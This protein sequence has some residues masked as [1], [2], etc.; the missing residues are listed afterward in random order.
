MALIVQLS[1]AQ[2]K[3]ISGTVSDENGLPLLGATV[4][5]SG[6]SSGTT[7][8]FDGNYKINATTGDVLSFSYVGYESQNI[9]VGA[10]NTVNVTLQ[11]DNTLDEV[12]VTAYG[13]KRAARETVY[14]TQ[15]ISNEDLVIVQPQSVASTLAGKVAGLQI[16][17]QNNGVNPSS[18]I[19]LRGLRSITQ[20]NAPLIVIDNSISSQGAFDQ[21]N[22]NDVESINTLKG[23]TAAALYGSRASNGA[24]LV[25]TKKGTGVGKFTV[26][27]N[28]SFNIQ[29]V[30]YIPEFQDE[31]GSGWQGVYE[32]IENTNWGPAFDG[33]LRR[34]G[35]VF[36]DGSFQTVPYAPVKDQI[37]DFYNTGTSSNNTVYLSGSDESASFYLSFGKL[38]TTGVMP[39]DT[40]QRNTFRANATKNIGNLTLGIN[41]SYASDKTSVVGNTIGAQDR[42]IYWFILN[43]PINTP[44]TS[45]KDWEN[46]F[47][48]SPDGYPNGYYENPYWAI[49]NN[50]DNDSSRRF[51]A[52]ISVDWEAADWLNLTAR[53]GVNNL[54]RIGK[55]YR[56]AS[57]FQDALLVIDDSRPNPSTSWVEDFESQRS[58]YTADFLASGDFNLNEDFTLK[59]VLGVSNFTRESRGSTIRANNLIIPNM[60]DITNT[61]Q[62]V[63]PNVNESRQRTYGVFTDLT[64]GYKDFLFLN[65]SGRKDWTSTLPLDKNSYFYPGYGLSFLFSDLIDS[66]VLNY[67]RLTI[68][69]S[70][71]Y[72]D[73]EPYEIVEVFTQQIGFPYS[74]TGING[75]ILDATA[76]DENI[77]KEQIKTLEFGLTLGF[78]KDRIKL[79]SSYYKTKTTDL[80]TRATTPPSSASDSYLTNIGLIE[81]SGLEL[82]LDLT[83]IRTE[84]FNWDISTNY[85]SSQQEVVKI[86][87]TLSEIQIGGY[88]TYGI[89]AVEGEQMP[90]IKATSY[91][92]DNQGRVIIDASTGNPIQG[93]LKN[94]GQTTPKYILG[95]TNSFNYKGFS[96]TATMDYRTGHVYVSQLADQ[97]EFT[98]RSQASVSANRQDFV[99]PNSV[100]NAG[101]AD[102]PVYV[103]NTNIQV[104]DGLQNFW[105]DTY[106]DI[107]ENYVF[108][109]TAVKLRELSLGY[110]FPA[111]LLKNTSLSRVN[112]SVYARNVFTW[113]PAEN[114]FSDPEFNGFGD[115]SLTAI[116]DGA[117]GTG[118]ASNSIGIGGYNQAPPTR[119]FGFNL[120]IEF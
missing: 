88:T 75:F 76:V 31:Y 53:F 110:Q 5:I 116:S 104:T 85:T 59:T 10:S 72:N 68:N 38:N 82:T 43:A 95:L 100:Y 25:T 57:T 94:L 109:A 20:S 92:R 113:L 61:T 16:N 63:T 66:S 56:N 21:L 11:L 48:S 106:N 87:E 58:T 71:V 18:Q 17:V 119:T 32:A 39:S 13:I 14:Q 97:M 33:T 51:T 67:G 50:R 24:I 19:L 6:T 117:A 84:N 74:S 27:I 108:D 26:G 107:K 42:P 69:N 91:Q 73:F 22:P 105:T 49:D 64:F 28:S 9:S 40:Y 55:E 47:F 79:N 96:L 98:G 86:S 70:T 23:A 44:L 52:N 114:K 101:T 7:T 12:V 45:Y 80:I 112:L 46:D 93:D 8:D 118:T 4:L 115:S 103:E 37:K 65:V 34:L 99:F 54:N 41:S 78:L 2:Q 62:Q 120:N 89:Y 1:F 29:S 102:N 3:T 35:P 111:K 81:G 90:L 60:Y 77:K 30:S 83:P 36:S 15:K